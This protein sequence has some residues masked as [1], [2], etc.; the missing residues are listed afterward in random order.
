MTN[1]THASDGEPWAIPGTVAFTEDGSPRLLAGV[2]RHCAKTVFPPPKICPECWG[3]DIA[4]VQLPTTGVLYTY[5]VVH[6][7][8][9][10]WKTPYVLAFV[11]FKEHDVRVAGVVKGPDGWRPEL[12]SKVRV[13][14]DVICTDANGQPVRAHCFQAAE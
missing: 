7:G 11:D 6:A 12:D 8:R 3:E 4:P 13:G 2:C 9:P 1:A 14:T 5:S 10:G